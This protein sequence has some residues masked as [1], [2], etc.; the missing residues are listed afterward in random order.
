MRHEKHGLLV[1]YYMYLRIAPRVREKKQK[2]NNSQSKTQKNG[3][4]RQQ[5]HDSNELR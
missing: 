3:S 4:I 1:T 5:M 2:Q